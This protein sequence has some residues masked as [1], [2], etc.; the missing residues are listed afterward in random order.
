[1]TDF[2]FQ[3]SVIS[4]NNLEIDPQV[5]PSVYT[6]SYEKKPLIEGVQMIQLKNI[7]GED[8][9]FNEVIRINENG[10]LEQFPGFKLAQVNRTS[11]IG[12]TVKGWH[13][14]YVQDE[15]WYVPA[16]YFILVGLWDIRKNSPTC[17]Q[18]NRFVL[19]GNN[20][21]LLFIPHG[22]AHGSAVY[23][24]ESANLYYFINKKFDVKNPDE[25]RI[26]W[27]KLGK[28]FWEPQRD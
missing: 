3:P 21:Q 20:P 17:G 10:E 7:I 4:Q 5:A 2:S 22:V 16:P 27:D 13:L 26:P 6:Q 25:R 23:A 28:S 15:L 14:H 8:G 12:G 11:Q 19:D 18:V 9:S 1:M 24:Q